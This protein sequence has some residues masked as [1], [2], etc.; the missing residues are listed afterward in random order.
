MTDVSQAVAWL[1]EIGVAGTQV[2]FTPVNLPESRVVRLQRLYPR[3][4]LK[5]TSATM[6]IPRPTT[7]RI[8]G[9]P[10]RDRELLA[11]AGEIIDTIVLDGAPAEAATAT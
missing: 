9:T 10:L 1:T 8:G 4:V 5:A 11:W 7:A 3:S 2:R 6:L